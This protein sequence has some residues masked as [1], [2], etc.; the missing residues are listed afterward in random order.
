MRRINAVAILTAATMAALGTSAQ[1][2][3]TVASVSGSR[4]SDVRAGG[5]HHHGGG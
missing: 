2:A 1:A 5:A 4:H 3:T